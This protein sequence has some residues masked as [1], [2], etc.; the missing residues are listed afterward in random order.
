VKDIDHDGFPDIVA[1]SRSPGGATIWKGDGQGKWRRVQTPLVGGDVRSI[2]TG[3]VNGDG[4]E[5]LIIGGH[6][7]RKGVVVLL[8][9]KDGSWRQGASPIEVGSY[10]SVKCVDINHDGNLDIVAANSSGDLEGGIQAWLGDGRGNWYAEVGPDSSKIYRDVDIADL[11]NDGHLDIV[12]AAWGHPGGIHLFLGSGDGAWSAYT[13]PAD[14]GDFW[15][16]VASDLNRDG[17]IDIAATTYYHGIK[18]WYGNHKGNWKETDFP[19]SE[20]FYWDILATDFNQDDRVDLVATSVNSQGVHVW[21]GGRFGGWSAMTSG[22]PDSG[23]FYGLATSDVD[24]DGNSDLVAASFSQGV[25]VWLAGRD[26][27]DG[28]QNVILNPYEPEESENREPLRMVRV[29]DVSFETNSTTFTEAG[30]SVM[31]EMMGHLEQSHIESIRIEGHADTSESAEEGGSLMTLSESR[32]EAVARILGESHPAVTSAVTVTGFADSKPIG[33][34]LAETGFP[35]TRVSVMATH[36][37]GMDESMASPLAAQAHESVILGGQEISEYRIG[38]GDILKVVFWKQFSAEEYE[39]L[40]RPGGSLSFSMVDDLQVSGLTA[41]ELD[42]LLTEKLSR[43]FKHPRVDIL[44][45]EHHS[46]KVMLMGAIN[47]L[48]RQPTGPGV[49]VLNKQTRV[50]EMLTVAGGP[51]PTANLKKVTVTRA[52]GTT[53]QVNLY[54]AI[55]QSDLSQDIPIYPGDSIFVPETSEGISKVYV[56][57][58]VKNPGFYDLQEGMSVVDAIIKAGSFTKDAVQNSTQVVRGDLSKPEVIPVDFKRFFNDGDLSANLAL[59]DKDIVYVPRT[60]MAS[61]SHFLNQLR[62]GLDLILFP[63]SYQALENAA[64]D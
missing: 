57:G 3:D 1:G 20:G 53:Q 54:K 55:F 45:Q 31:N 9:E 41:T 10:E 51:R 43:Y 49:Y 39:V 48:V 28:A 33:E 6:K 38:A 37:S 62:P 63:L 11:N 60:K 35:G 17:S 18:V 14:N 29:F 52:N 22:L 61:V 2:A 44:V 4:Q 25:H 5:D 21:L 42:G 58:E 8:Q 40:V 64:S 56:L 26:V 36:L 15:G 24:G 34:S 7:G 27:P 47:S 13:T 50:M 23:A 59:H 46:Q 32:A 16:I 30:Q 12:G 19:A